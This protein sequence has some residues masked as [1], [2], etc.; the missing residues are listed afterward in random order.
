MQKTS[1]LG[2]NVTISPVGSVLPLNGTFTTILPL[3]RT[4]GWQPH[5]T[6]DEQGLLQELRNSLIHTIV[7]SIR[8][9]RY[10]LGL[11]WLFFINLFDRAL[12]R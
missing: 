3:D 11:M 10:L 7:A 9:G 2:I 12:Y 8:I 5:Y 1:N 4:Q 6:L